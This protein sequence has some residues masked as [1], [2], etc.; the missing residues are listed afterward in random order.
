MGN[1]M[2]MG[3]KWKV[4]TKVEIK[5]N[6]NCTHLEMEWKIEMEMDTKIELEMKMEIDM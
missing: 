3:M 1:K 4:E 6:Y 2:E 5:D